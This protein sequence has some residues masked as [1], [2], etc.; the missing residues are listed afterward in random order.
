[1]TTLSGMTIGFIGLGLMGK[2]LCRN[3]MRA[4][5]K[6]IVTNRS[7]GPRIEL[8]REGAIALETP[9]AVAEQ[10]EMVII[11]VADTRAVE[12]VLTGPDG[13][14]EQLR[15]NS[16]VIDMGT[17]LMTKTR[18]FADMAGHKGGLYLDAPVSGGTIGAEAGTL[19]IMAGG[20]DVAFQRALPVLEILGGTV[21]HVGAVGAGQVAKAANQVIVGLTIG[22]VAEALALAKAAGVDPGKVREA[23]RGGFADSRILE[24]HGERMVTDDYRL[25]ARSTTQRKDMDQALYLASKLGLDLP[26]TRLSRTLYDQLIESGGADLD[27]AAL[28]TILEKKENSH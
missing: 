21:T 27:H 13:V 28:F 18:A 7:E 9:A 1:M 8:Q 20:S 24:I 26:A 15:E 16:L 14:F 22:A 17:T 12:A 4:G 2:P 3:L 10:A 6:L 11:M 19:T 25:G 5:A 23:L